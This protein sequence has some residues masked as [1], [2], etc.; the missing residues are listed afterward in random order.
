MAH[1]I[2]AEGRLV[3]IEINPLLAGLAIAG[4]PLWPAPGGEIMARSDLRCGDGRVFLREAPAASLDVVFLDPMFQRPRPAAP[5]F[6]ALR[7]LADQT[8]LSAE[9]IIEARRVAR[10]WVLV[11]DAWPGKE[12]ERLK[13]PALPFRRS[14]EIVFGRIAGAG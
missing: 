13:I 8:P 14:A 3:G 4:A 2:G 11:K 9:D 12:L 1:V 6:A 10:R 5:D 7:L